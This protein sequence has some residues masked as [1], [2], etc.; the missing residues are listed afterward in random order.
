MAEF[1]IH[2]GQR[3]HRTLEYKNAAGGPGKTQDPPTWDLSD[4]LTAQVDVDPDGLHGTIAYNGTVGDLTITSV[5]DG[6]LGPEV[7]RIVLTD[8]FHML[9]PLGAAGGESNVSEEEPIPA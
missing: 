9:A 2:P 8:V 7:N 3:R 1:N 6:D 4:E 5:A